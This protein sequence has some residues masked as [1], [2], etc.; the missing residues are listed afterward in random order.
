MTAQRE[1]YAP[2]LDLRF[3][4]RSDRGPAR[5]HNEDYVGCFVPG[6]EMQRHSKG[7]IFLV[8]D[9]MGGHRAGQVASR[10]A[11]ERVMQ[12]YLADAAHM[13]GDSLARAF[14]V[15]NQVLHDR[16]LSDLS[17][18][19]M[20]TT[21]VAAAVLGRRVCVANV[22]DSRAYLI[23]QRGIVQ[24]TR[25]HSWVEKQVQA[26]LLTR[27]QAERHPQRN[28]ITRALGAKPSVE[29]DLFE[30]ELHDGDVLL[31][32]TDGVSGSLSDQEMVRIIRSQPPDRAAHELVAQ[33]NA[34]RGEDNAT[35]M[36]V[37]A[38]IPQPVDPR[39][40]LDG[41]RDW[42]QRPGMLHLGEQRQRLVVGLAA[43][44]FVSCL[45]AAIAVLPALMQK[46]GGD[47]VA[48]PGLAPLRDGRLAGK[49]QGQ[50]AAYLGYQD[51]AELETAH[52]GQFDSKGPDALDLWPA[53]R[54]V[55][56]VGLVHHWSCQEQACSFFLKMHDREYQV[57]YE[58]APSA[59]DA[60][61]GPVE[62]AGD[63]G[64]DLNNWQVRVFGYQQADGATVRAQFIERGSR[65]W[66]WW[67]RAWTMVY[68]VHP[69]A[70]AVWVYGIV[71][72][73][74][75]GLLDTERYL[76]L[77]QGEQVLSRGTW[78][79]GKRSTA[80][81]EEQVYHLIGSRYV[82]LTLETIPMPEPTVT[83]MPTGV[84]SNNQ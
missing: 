4:H 36:V 6:D 74:P 38:A 52:P 54:G 26:G 63:G 73:S 69:W 29:I 10:T 50:C 76:A 3:G 77:E 83:L 35:A 70:Q 45:G 31:L 18:A 42:L 14:R 46:L 32:C 43:L 65:W 15:A 41:V 28:V 78:G 30:R 34:R 27:E 24:I 13:P 33:A 66:A 20:G 68:Q 2:E 61:P 39:R 55:F 16:A 12:E 11:V 49:T 84:M 40:A 67:Q 25:D 21:L 56:L 82:P 71:D 23:S 79:V 72:K 44:V 8:A 48:A 37:A 58:P 7:A 22:G 51:V 80:F 64:T 59:D 1:P 62:E 5:T 53:Q 47:P 75:N 17:R 19:G 60:S 81:Y 9:G 57:S